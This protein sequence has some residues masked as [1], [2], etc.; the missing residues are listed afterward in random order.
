MSRFETHRLHFERRIGRH[1]DGQLLRRRHHAA[2][3]MNRELLDHAVDR[4]GQDLKLGSLLGL[5]EIAAETGG[6]A[7]RFC[8]LAEQRAMKFGHRLRTRFR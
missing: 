2:D 5:C 8:K 3:G 4:R 7:L 6:F 1:D